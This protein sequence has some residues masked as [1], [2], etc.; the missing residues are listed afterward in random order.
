MELFKGRADV[1]TNVDAI[2]KDDSGRLQPYNLNGPSSVGWFNDEISTFENKI[3][4]LIGVGG[5]GE[6]ITR[7]L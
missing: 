7:T 2:V 5:V 4:I 1:P 6:P 3:I